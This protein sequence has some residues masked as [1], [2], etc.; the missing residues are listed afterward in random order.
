[1]KP[2]IVELL[3]TLLLAALLASAG[4]PV[5]SAQPSY[6]MNVTPSR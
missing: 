5:D 4:Q 1:M 6:T 2:R 3:P